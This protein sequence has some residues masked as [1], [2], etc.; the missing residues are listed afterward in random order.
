MANAKWVLT[1]QADN[2]NWEVYKLPRY[3]CDQHVASGFARDVTDHARA[4]AVSNARLIAAAP[5]L[6]EALRN[7]V[8]LDVFTYDYEIMRHIATTTRS[9]RLVPPSPAQ[10]GDPRLAGASAPA[11]DL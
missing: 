2:S 4:E 7:L 5:E 10:S 11:G 3:P 6:L 1:K 8:A 9:R